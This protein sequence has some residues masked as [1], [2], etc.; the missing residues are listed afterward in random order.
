MAL[1]FVSCRDTRVSDLSPLTGMPVT[2]LYCENTSVTD[3]S[4]LKGMPLKVLRCDF[5]PERDAEIL[6]S[7]KTLETINEKPAKEFWKDIDGGAGPPLDDAWV[8]RVAALPAEKQAAVVVAELK[9]RNPDF[10]GRATPTVENGV[11]TGLDFL[12]DDVRDVAPVRALAGLKS[13]RCCGS[14]PGKGRLWNLAPLKGMRL[15]TLSCYNN[16][17]VDDLSPLQG[18][19]LQE[20]WCGY[21]GVTDLSPLKGTPLAVLWFQCTTV[22]DISP[23]KGMPLTVLCC[24]GTQVSDL[25]PLRGA[26][27]TKLY[28]DNSLVSDL[29]P[30]KGMP[31]TA[32]WC[33]NWHLNAQ[34]SDLSPL[35][36]MPLKELRCD[37]KPE[38]DA[39]ILRS[40]TTLET[41]NEKPAKEFWKEVDEKKP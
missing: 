35:K 21:T 10:D 6:R 13:L 16:T 8:K 39:E 11:V 41:I 28:C 5:K 23:V 3:L 33:F 38:R 34:A 20:L 12:T 31:L 15:T 17:L 29:S 9:V 2:E 18:M 40:I 1:T 22:S 4:P 19:P 14:Q 36:G 7:L 26:A 37:F 27:L 30:L 32:L 24:G 25:S